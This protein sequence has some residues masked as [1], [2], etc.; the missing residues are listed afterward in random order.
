RRKE[1]REEG[2]RERKGKR[3]KRKG[4]KEREKETEGKREGKREREREGG[5]EGEEGRE[6]ER[7]KE[8]ERKGRGEREGEKGREKKRKKEGGRGGERKKEREKGKE[9]ERESDSMIETEKGCAMLGT[10]EFAL[11]NCEE[12]RVGGE[13]LCEASVVWLMLLSYT[14]ASLASVVLCKT[15]SGAPEPTVKEA[16]TKLEIQTVLAWLTVV[17]LATVPSYPWRLRG[18]GGNV[19]SQVDVA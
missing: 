12:G 16:A 14:T 5:G 2:R 1:K 4:E 6:G 15:I 9:R 11:H 19:G 7:R 17:R 3:K 10:K 18:G 13:P 8:K